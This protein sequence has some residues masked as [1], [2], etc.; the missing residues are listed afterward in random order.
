M[1]KL[2]EKLRGSGSSNTGKPLK[3]G[4]YDG[5][6]GIYDYRPGKIAGTYNIYKNNK[7][8][9]NVGIDGFKKLQK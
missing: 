1:A 7:F 5:K 8:V 2:F 4:N 6:V 9:K 3:K